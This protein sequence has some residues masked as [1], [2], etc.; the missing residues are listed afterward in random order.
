[1][2]NENLLGQENVLDDDRR[3]N[4]FDVYARVVKLVN[5]IWFCEIRRT[6]ELRKSEILLF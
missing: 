2:K 3:I 1:M 6:E 5:A 4:F